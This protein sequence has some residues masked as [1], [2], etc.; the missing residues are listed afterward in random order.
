VEQT[1]GEWSRTPAEI[2]FFW[3]SAAVGIR[4][5][6]EKVAI[7]FLPTRSGRQ[8][9]EVNFRGEKKWGWGHKFS[10]HSWV[11]HRKYRRRVLLGQQGWSRKSVDGLRR[12]A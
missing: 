7:P 10:C 1:A 9:E 11:N 3:F 12:L 8:V 5:W 2:Y 4:S 6:G